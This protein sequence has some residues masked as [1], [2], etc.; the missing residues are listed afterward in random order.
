MAYRHST[1]WYA[2]QEARR[3][4]KKGF[5]PSGSVTLAFLEAQTRRSVFTPRG[6]RDGAALAV[7]SPFVLGACVAI[8]IGL[9]VG[10]GLRRVADPV[11]RAKMK[12]EFQRDLR[13]ITRP[14]YY[15]R[16]TERRRR[17]AAERRKLTRRTTT[18]P[19]PAPEALLAAWNARKSSKTAMLRLAGM[20]QDLECYVDNTLKLDGSGN[21]L[22]RQGGIRGWLRENLPELSPHYKMLMRYKALAVKLR[23]ATGTKDPV[24]TARL[25]DGRRPKIV[26]ELLNAG[27]QTFDFLEK[28]LAFELDPDSVFR[29]F[30][31]EGEIM[32]SLAK[33][34]P[35]DDPSALARRRRPPRVK[36]R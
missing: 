14:I 24:P 8:D 6:Y 34:P 35:P 33:R 31:A 22:G 7:L 17:L 23:Q 11:E 20:M 28:R 18:S 1:Y 29:T 10:D 2:K 5:R 16:E 3:R 19:M 25:L 32:R 12:L 30:H 21:I 26:D 15:A 9:A 4:S 36:H 27:Q 13:I